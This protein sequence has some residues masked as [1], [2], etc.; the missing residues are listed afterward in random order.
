MENTSYFV[1]A[2]LAVGAVCLAV[3]CA[4]AVGLKCV[5]WGSTMISHIPSP[6][7]IAAGITGLIAGLSAEGSAWIFFR[8]EGV[9]NAISEKLQYMGCEKKWRIVC[10]LLRRLFFH[11]FLQFLLFLFLSQDGDVRYLIKQQ[12]VMQ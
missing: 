3:N 6:Q 8:E 5:I 11:F 2:G 1:K 7:I 9:S 10:C 12:L 4:N